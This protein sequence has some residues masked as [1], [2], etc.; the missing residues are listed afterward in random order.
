MACN[1][2]KSYN[3]LAFNSLVERAWRRWH[4]N[5]YTTSDCWEESDSGQSKLFNEKL[6]HSLRRNLCLRHAQIVDFRLQTL[7]VRFEEH[8]AL[9]CSHLIFLHAFDA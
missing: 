2:R 9:K 3:I 5:T 4:R 8:F 6:K 1:L 7:S